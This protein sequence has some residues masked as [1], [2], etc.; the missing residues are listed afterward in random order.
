MS[1]LLTTPDLIV[2]STWAQS[3]W[4]VARS[5]R[6]PSNPDRPEHSG[7]SFTLRPQWP[8]QDTIPAEGWYQITR[9]HLAIDGYDH[10]VRHR[11]SWAT[12]TRWLRLWTPTDTDQ[13]LA[14]DGQHQAI[15]HPA[16][17][18]AISPAHPGYK[19]MCERR[20]QRLEGGG[21][22]QMADLQQQMRALVEQYLTGQHAPLHQPGLF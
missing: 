20:D 7:G 12:V 15:E 18:L 6:T 14:L 3:T 4:R 10:V 19:A 5:L 1:T 2:I 9:R 13:L 22:R 8:Q 21:Y 11:I 17:E 16:D